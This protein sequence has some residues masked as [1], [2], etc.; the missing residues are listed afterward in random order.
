MLC[1]FLLDNIRKFLP[2]VYTFPSH[3][4]LTG[5]TLLDTNSLV[6]NSP[7]I[8][9]ENIGYSHNSQVTIMQMGMS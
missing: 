6:L 3:K 8:H 7:Q 4:F 2:G 1:Y 5:S 9:L